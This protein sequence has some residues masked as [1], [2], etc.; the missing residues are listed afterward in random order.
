MNNEIS[1][2][3]EDYYFQLDDEQCNVAFMQMA[4]ALFENAE[5][6]FDDD[7]AIF[8]KADD[9]YLGMLDEQIMHA[10]IGF[11]TVTILMYAFPRT[12]IVII[13]GG[14]LYAYFTS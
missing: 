7:N 11:L 12:S 5:L 4:L 6:M 10:A 14:I 13:V 2:K 9:E 8:W 3:I 1:D